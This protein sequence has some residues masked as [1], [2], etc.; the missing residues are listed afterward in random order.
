MSKEQTELERLRQENMLLREQLFMNTENDIVD[1]EWIKANNSLLAP[2][3][4][5]AAGEA[6]LNIIVL[7]ASG[8]LAKKKIYPALFRLYGYGFLPDNVHV[9]G[10]ARSALDINEFKKKIS[11]NFKGFD[12]M[13]ERFL[14]QCFYHSGGYDDTTSFKVL[15][16]KLKESE[17]TGGNRLFFMAIPPSVFVASA[18]SLHVGCR[19]KT[20]WNRV[21]VEKPFGRDFDTSRELSKELGALFTEDELYRI[22]HYLGKELVQ[23]LMVLRFANSVFEPIWNRHHIASVQITFKEDIGTEG[24]GGYFDTFGIIRDV[25]QNHLTQILSL[26][27]MEPPVSLCA[28]DIRDEK[29]KLLRACS[30]VVPADM[31]IG[32]YVS[33]GKVPGYLEDPGVPKDS[34]CPTYA[35]AAVHIN[36]ARWAGVPFILKCGKALNERKAEVRVQFRNPTNGLFSHVLDRNELVLRV[37]PDEAMYMK[38]NTK[39]PGLTSEIVLSELDLSYRQRFE[40]ASSLPDAYERLLLDVV[41]GDHNLFVRNDELDAAWKIFTPILHTLEGE[42]I[43]PHEYVFGS[44]GLPAADEMLHRYGITRSQNYS[45]PR[46]LSNP[47]L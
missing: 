28:E 34:T 9:W 42:K 30:P 13:R 38:M 17:Q 27:A 19:S 26:L 36:N 20:G 14:S 47:R 24:R 33:N 16:A 8:D 31:V 44:R 2:V 32:Q 45:W 41:R 3:T 37:Q 7:G 46:V 35:C 10:F 5:S 18:K 40:A 21:V 22:D 39:V 25:M 15:D 4:T 6:F 29:V 1:N 11:T 43:K 12:D 23:N